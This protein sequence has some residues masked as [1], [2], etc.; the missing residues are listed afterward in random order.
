MISLMSI[1]VVLD[2]ASASLVSPFN[3]VPIQLPPSNLVLL[4]A[5]LKRFQLRLIRRQ[6]TSP[7]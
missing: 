6:Q 4:A 7:L 3:V 5:E 2:V 1:E